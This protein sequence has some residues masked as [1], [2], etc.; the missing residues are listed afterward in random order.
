VA[1]A[2]L[3]T[4]VEA[5]GGDAARLANEIEKLSLFTGGQ[6]PVTE[7]D[8]AM[9]SPDARESTIFLLV[10]ALS[11][12]DRLTSLDILETLVRDG[13]YLPLALT[14]LAAQFRFALTAREEGLRTPQQIQGHFS[15]IGVAMWSSRAQQ[16]QQ[17]LAAFDRKR[18]ELAIAAVYQADKG[19][20]DRSPD[21]RIVMEKLIFALTR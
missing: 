4:L 16:V 9:L 5:L 8:I 7:Q 15:K 2:V 14:F 13:E 3:D 11:R 17:T 12:G 19:F 1:P 6:R 20:R 18:L 10:N 21:D